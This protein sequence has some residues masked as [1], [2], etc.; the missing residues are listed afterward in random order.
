MEYD[1][2]TEREG[3]YAH[4]R[5]KAKMNKTNKKCMHVLNEKT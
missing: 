4:S 3:M 1:I 5:R 2:N